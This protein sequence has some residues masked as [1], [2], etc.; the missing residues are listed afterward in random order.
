VKRHSATFQRLEEDLMVGPIRS[1]EV[2][3]TRRRLIIMCDSDELQPEGMSA[4]DGRQFTTHHD[5]N[6]ENCDEEIDT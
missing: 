4:V 6:D 1:V 3:H 2:D 5:E